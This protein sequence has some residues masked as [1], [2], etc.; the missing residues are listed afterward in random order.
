[1][2]VITKLSAFCFVFQRTVRFCN[3]LATVIPDAHVYYRRG[4]ALKKVIPQCIARGFTYLMVINEDRKVP[5]ILWLTYGKRDIATVNML[6]AYD[7]LMLLLVCVLLLHALALKSQTR[8]QYH[9][10]NSVAHS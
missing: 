6:T 10:P 2:V 3:Q 1:M 7:T 4:L 9:N 5:S 8:L